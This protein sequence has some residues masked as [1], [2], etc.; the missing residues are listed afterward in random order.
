[1]Y[2]A[3]VKGGVGKRGRSASVGAGLVR[4]RRAVLAMGGVGYA[5]SPVAVAL[6][7]HGSA[8]DGVGVGTGTGRL[9]GTREVGSGARPGVLRKEENLEAR[10]AVPPMGRRRRP[11]RS[12]RWGRGVPRLLH[13]AGHHRTAASGVSLVGEDGQRLPP[14]PGTLGSPPGGRDGGADTG[15][16]DGG[17]AV[18]TRVIAVEEPWQSIYL[19]SLLFVKTTADLRLFDSREVRL[20]EIIEGEAGEYDQHDDD[21]GTEVDE[22]FY[23]ESFFPGE[24]GDGESLSPGSEPAGG[25]S[26]FGGRRS[27]G[28]GGNDGG[29]ARS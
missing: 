29:G 24:G 17:V 12:G 23:Q 21:V 9:A 7:A 3:L 27:S 22:E 15:D 4:V 1:W 14:P 10:G 13:C 25:G 16:G 20:F 28:G 26:V 18:L 8:S 2:G 11:Q 19:W 6:S 5:S